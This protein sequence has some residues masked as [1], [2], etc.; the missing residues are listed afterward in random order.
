MLAYGIADVDTAAAYQAYLGYTAMPATVP[1]AIFRSAQQTA[2]ASLN[3]AIVADLGTLTTTPDSTRLAAASTVAQQVITL[4][5]TVAL[6]PPAVS[7]HCP[8]SVCM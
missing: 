7:P 2:S 8:S 1:Y 3:T 4:Q 5:E 6:P